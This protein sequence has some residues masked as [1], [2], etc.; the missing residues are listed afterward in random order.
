MSFR[1]S[2]ASRSTECVPMTTSP[3]SGASTVE[4][5]LIMVVFPA[6][7]GP[8]SPNTSWRPMEKETSLTAGA[9]SKLLLR[10]VAVRKPL[11]MIVGF[12]RLPGATD[13][14]CRPGDAEAFER[15]R[16]DGLAF[17]VDSSLLECSLAKHQDGYG[18]GVRVDQPVLLD[19][20]LGVQL[21][22]HRP[23]ALVG[24]GRPD[25]HRQVRR[26]LDVGAGD[27]V[28]T[29]PGHEQQV[30]LHH[31]SIRQHNVGGGEVD[32]A[33]V[34]L[35]HEVAEPRA[36]LGL[37]VLVGHIRRRSH[38]KLSIQELPSLVIGGL[39]V[40]LVSRLGRGLGGDHRMP[41]IPDRARPGRSRPS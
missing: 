22:L 40:V 26:A 5:I 29:L 34:T 21:A 14:I 12:V 38:V 30:G 4:S 2:S 27:D 19:A 20:V 17:A 24:G 41:S 39:Q 35:L 18:Y 16:R 25:L 7:L 11:S 15:G 13:G 8:S 31:V 6:P 37:S 33:E 23:V 3:A 1:T 9:P 32:A 28:L 36:Q 10:L